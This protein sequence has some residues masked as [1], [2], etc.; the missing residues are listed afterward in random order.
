MGPNA[1]REYLEKIRARYRKAG[2][3]DKSRILDEFCAICGHHRKHAIRL[4]RP[5]AKS[6]ARSGPRPLYGRRELVPIK[7]I[8]LL[9]EQPCSKR[10]QAILPMWLPQ[11]E[12]RHGALEDDVRRRVLSISPASIDRLLASSR[13]RMA[14]RQPAGTKPGSLLRSQIPVRTGPWDTDQPGYLEADTV[15]HC[16]ASLAGSFVW[17]ITFTDIATGWTECRSVWNKGAA[18]VVDQTRAIE[19]IL[20]FEILGFD[21]DNGSEFLNHHLWRHLAQRPKPIIFTRSRPYKKNDQAH[22]EQKNW[23]HVRQLLGYQRLCHPALLPL[24]DR[25]YELWGLFNNFFCPNMKLLEKRREGSRIVK[26]YHPPLTPCDRLLNNPQ[27]DEPTRERLRRQR[28]Q[29]DPLRLK[30]Q[31]ERQLRLV[32]DAQHRAEESTLTAAPGEAPSAQALVEAL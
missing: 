13:A 16:G 18:G 9:S 24:I 1:R 19:R 4:L 28:E 27:I 12:A 3:A 29:L 25:L 5:G 31:I 10:L 23:T 7:A 20:P 32:F 8:W 15:A 21:C 17:S 11:W 26:R 22:V 30:K 14:A 6:A 2:R